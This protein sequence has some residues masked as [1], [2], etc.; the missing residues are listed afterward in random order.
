MGYHL[1]LDAH[2]AIHGF[3]YGPTHQPHRFV[4]TAIRNRRRLFYP[5]PSQDI[6]GA[7][8]IAVFG[9]LINTLTQ[10]MSLP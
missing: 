10:I 9:T 8:G 1:A 6:G 7:V 2:G 3:G 5:G 4:G